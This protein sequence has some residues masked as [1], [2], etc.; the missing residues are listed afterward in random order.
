MEHIT[1]SNIKF[2]F[3]TAVAVGKFDTLH[4]GHQALI[5]KI[6]DESRGIGLKTAVFSFEPSPSVVFGS[7]KYPY[8]F[9]S[10]EKRDIL[11]MPPFES[12]DF[13]IEYP[14]DRELFTM[15][16]FDFLKSI[17]KDKLNCELFAA[18]GG[19]RFGK[20]RAG[21]I[22]T[23][24]DAAEVL[25]FKT[26]EL[27][28]VFYDGKAISSSRIRELIASY[29]FSRARELMG[30]P[31]FITGC[32]EPGKK[33]GRKLGFPT[34]NIEIPNRKF[35]PAD[36]VYVTACQAEEQIYPSVSNIGANPSFGETVKKCETYIFDFDEELYNKRVTVYFYARIRGEENFSSTDALKS[37]IALDVSEARK[38][39]EKIGENELW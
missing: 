16:P 28:E 9:T 14:F 13:F 33:L 30:R 31:Y 2:N 11:S 25:G 4:L 39:W 5:K 7:E 27:A 35:I 8:V 24:K 21:D 26:L 12:V 38:Q 15:Q 17:I 22:N 36:G 19:Y 3:P 10:A 32:V 1:S 20:D 34:V 37:R 29:D 23:I 18:T 6:I